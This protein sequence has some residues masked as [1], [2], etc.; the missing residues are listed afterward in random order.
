MFVSNRLLRQWSHFSFKILPSSWHI[1]L[2]LLAEVLH[3]FSNW[4]SSARQSRSAAVHPS[5]WELF[6]AWV[7]AYGKLPA[8]SPNMTILTDLVWVNLATIRFYEV[9]A[10][11]SQPLLGDV[12]SVSKCTKYIPTLLNVNVN[13]P[14]LV[15]MCGYKLPFTGQNLAQKGLA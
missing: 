13:S 10:V 6:W 14:N 1:S 15:H 4:I 5:T 11:W 9:T 3:T 7:A 12:C 8:L 2:E